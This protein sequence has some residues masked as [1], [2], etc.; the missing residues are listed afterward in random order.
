MV[1]I[2]SSSAKEVKTGQKVAIKKI[3]KGVLNAES[4][5]V[6][7]SNLIRQLSITS[8]RQSELLGRSRF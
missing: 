3:T 4:K 6:A 5:V 8:R 1:A 7:H 2:T